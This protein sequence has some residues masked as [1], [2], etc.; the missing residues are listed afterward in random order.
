VTL[1]QAG[2]FTEELQTDG[3][4]GPLRALPEFRKLLELSRKG[5]R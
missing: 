3:D 1:T 2:T 5:A 4:L